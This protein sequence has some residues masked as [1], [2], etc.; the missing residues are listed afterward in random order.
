MEKN[1]RYGDSALNP[2]NIFC[3]EGDAS[4]KILVRMDDKITRITNSKELRKNDIVDLMGYMVL[5]CINK[6][7]TD[8]NDQID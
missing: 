6:G 7:W 3:K 4:T 5:L 2:S 1:K 8:F